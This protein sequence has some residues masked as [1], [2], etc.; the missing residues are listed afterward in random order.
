MLS[1]N[2]FLNLFH[3]LRKLNEPG[4]NFM[5]QSSR[6][7]LILLIPRPRRDSRK[8]LHG[9]IDLIDSPNMED[10]ALYGFHYFLFQHEI[11][12]I[13]SRNDYA[14]IAFQAA[15]AAKIEEALNFFVDSAD[16]L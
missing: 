2:R 8:N 1:G 13:A 16:R 14:L 6:E 10:T 3:R 15:G 4:L 5:I 11:L 9:F 12:N 7:E